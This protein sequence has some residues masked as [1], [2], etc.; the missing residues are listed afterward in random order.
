[1][2]EFNVLPAISHLSILG[3]MTT[4]FEIMNDYEP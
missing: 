4:Q 3:V 1:M 2:E